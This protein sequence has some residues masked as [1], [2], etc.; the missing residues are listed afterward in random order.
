VHTIPINTFL[1]SKT[2]YPQSE[3]IWLSVP[4]SPSGRL[5]M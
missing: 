2:D 1:I 4:L 3:E 5:Q